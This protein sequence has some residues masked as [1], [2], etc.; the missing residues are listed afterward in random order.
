VGKL[1]DLVVLGA[2]P[3]A[4]PTSELPQAPV[5]ATLIGGKVTYGSLPG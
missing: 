3:F 2:D 4:L 5:E 1:A